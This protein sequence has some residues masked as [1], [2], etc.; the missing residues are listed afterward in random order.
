MHAHTRR[1]LLTIICK[2][3]KSQ[4][5][6]QS[7]RVLSVRREYGDCSSLRCYVWSHALRKDDLNVGLMLAHP[8]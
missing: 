2:K 3:N 6:M 4:S 7:E 1:H 5:E 8:F